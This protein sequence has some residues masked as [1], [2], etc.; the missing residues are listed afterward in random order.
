[1]AHFIKFGVVRQIL[2]RHKAQD[3]ASAYSSGHIV[4]LPLML[5]G[6]ADKGDH[7]K[8]FAGLGD[9]FQFL[10]CGSQQGCLQKE[11]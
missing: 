11:I 8:L 4:K 2:L 6:K 3:P 1:M 10:L 7:V 5:P 9:F